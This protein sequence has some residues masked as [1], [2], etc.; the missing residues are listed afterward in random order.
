MNA[1]VQYLLDR[2]GINGQAISEVDKSKVATIE[3]PA[4]K[5]N[6]ELWIPFELVD[7]ESIAKAVHVG[8]GLFSLLLFFL[9]LAPSSSSSCFG[10]S[11]T[12]TNGLSDVTWSRASLSEWW[13]RANFTLQGMGA[14]CWFKKMYTKHYFLFYLNKTLV[15]YLFSSPGSR[16]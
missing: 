15:M 14:T 7:R 1:Q 5:S 8:I 4:S 2:G 16:L 13:L 11:M 10:C 12:N 6:D 3:W 9:R